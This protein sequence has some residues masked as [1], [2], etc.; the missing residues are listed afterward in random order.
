MDLV[1]LQMLPNSQLL[2]PCLV[3]D[4]PPRLGIVVFGGLFCEI[5]G[6]LDIE[7]LM[8]RNR[9]DAYFWC[10]VEKCGEVLTMSMDGPCGKEG[11]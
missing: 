11:E 7:I 8:Q 6:D 2:C 4:F 1:V 3:E 9:F 10:R 5:L